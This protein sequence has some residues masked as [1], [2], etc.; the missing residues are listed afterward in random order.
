ME[1]TEPFHRVNVLLLGFPGIFFQKK[2]KEPHLCGPCLGH[3]HWATG[4]NLSPESQ[5]YLKVSSIHRCLAA[6]PNLNHTL[7]G[8]ISPVGRGCHPPGDPASPLLP[9]FCNCLLIS[10]GSIS[11]HTRM[12]LNP[13]QG[14][15]L[16]H[17][18]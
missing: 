5:R 3:G 12:H 17:S 15:Q 8:R 4:F 13:T 10:S 1:F 18:I 7:H 11:L 14:L 9:C 16:G 2:K 6:A